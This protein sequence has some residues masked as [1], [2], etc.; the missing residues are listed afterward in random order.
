MPGLTSFIR[1]IKIL[2]K[3]EKELNYILFF[4]FILFTEVEKE[5]DAWLTERE[6]I[7]DCED[8]NRLRVEATDDGKARQ[9]RLV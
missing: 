6:E 2:N 1:I 3:I 7:P 9:R 8:G 5:E 4:I